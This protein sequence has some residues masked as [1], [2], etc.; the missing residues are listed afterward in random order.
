MNEKEKLE[1]TRS[2][3][4]NRIKHAKEN[5]RILTEAEAAVEDEEIHQHAIEARQEYRDA[6]RRGLI[7]RIQ[8]DNHD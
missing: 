5:P 6:L 7:P 2:R 8:P 3:L 1:A 4:A